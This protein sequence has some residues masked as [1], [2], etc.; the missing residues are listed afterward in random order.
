[1]ALTQMQLIQSLGEAMTWFEREL[2]WG[3]PPTALPHL[4]GRIGELYAALITNGQM[5]SSPFRQNSYIKRR[6]F[7][8]GSVAR[9]CHRPCYG[10]SSR[11]AM[12]KNPSVLFVTVLVKRTTSANVGLRYNAPLLS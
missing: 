12:R 7:P 2:S 4:C 1:M 3:V 9:R 6:L 8:H 10:T 5:A 11:L